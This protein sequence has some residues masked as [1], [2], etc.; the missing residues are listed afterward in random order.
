MQCYATS[1][2]QELKVQSVQFGLLS[3]EEVVKLSVASICSES[4]YDELGNPKF[5]GV[6]DPRLGAISRDYR[7]FT[8]KGCKYC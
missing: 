5:N 6:N 2:T 4:P 8:C 7:C 3:P 1:K